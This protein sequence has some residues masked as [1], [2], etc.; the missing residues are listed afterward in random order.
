MAILSA[1]QSATIRLLGQKPGTF[2]GSSN[3]FETEIADLVNE[4]AADIAKYQDWQGLTHF[5]TIAGD[6]S[7]TEFSLPDDYDR[8]LKTA[9]VQD[10][11]TWAWGYCRILDLNE[12]I[13]LVNSGWGPF[14]GVWAMYNSGLHFTP[15]PTQT[16]TYPYISKNWARDAATLE[17]KAAFTSDTD[18][19]LLPERL[20]TLGLVWRWRE[21]KKLDA[22]GDQEAF[23]KALDE[24][25][26]SD[27]GARVYRSNSRRRIP[28][29]GVAW[30]WALG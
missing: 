13:Y 27:K 11:T 26:S 19:F 24:Y 21:N 14:P 7:T 10:V 2:F 1:M 12:Y 22:S 30:P 3:V 5:A 25:G 20:L 6:G 4:V 8:M 23:I 15:A 29:V 18:T 9:E 28:G 16:A 17:L